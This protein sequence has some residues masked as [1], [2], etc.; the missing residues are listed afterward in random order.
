MPPAAVRPRRGSRLDQH[1]AGGSTAGCAALAAPACAARGPPRPPGRSCP[2][3]WPAPRPRPSGLPGALLQVPQD[4][5]GVAL[6]LPRGGRVGVLQQRAQERLHVGDEALGRERLRPM[7]VDQRRDWRSRRWRPA[8]PAASATSSSTRRSS[9]SAFSARQERQ[10][11]PEQLRL[12]VRQA[13]PHRHQEPDVALLLPPDGRGRMRLGR[14]QVAAVGG[15]RDF[16]LALGPAADRADLPPDGRARPAGLPLLAQWT[17]HRRELRTNRVRI[18]TPGDANK[19]QL[20]NRTDVTCL[21]TIG[22]YSLPKNRIGRIARLKKRQR[23]AAGDA[24][25][26]RCDGNYLNN[27]GLCREVAGGSTVGSCEVPT[28][29]SRR[30]QGESSGP[31]TV[32][33]SQAGRKTAGSRTMA[34]PLHD[35]TC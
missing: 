5:R 22:K 6:D 24:Q 14:G 18:A 7:L 10:D 35:A 12:P 29:R 25:D 13:L 8:P 1:G 32:A 27:K 11:D 21:R 9:G 23:T 30:D 15:A 20:V 17:L 28:R 19:T 26:A 31:G 34:V 4:H 3:P 33:G 2:A 16:D